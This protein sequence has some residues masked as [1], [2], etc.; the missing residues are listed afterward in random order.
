MA[1]EFLSACSFMSET[2]MF[3]YLLGARKRTAENIKTQFREELSI[4]IGKHPESS[5]GPSGSSSL[6]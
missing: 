6:D 2:F 3:N 5:G 1:I 4:Y